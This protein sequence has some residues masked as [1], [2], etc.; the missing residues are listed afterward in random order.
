LR[1]GRGNAGESRRK[2]VRRDRKL[3]PI[4]AI[5]GGAIVLVVAIIVASQI[6]SSNKKTSSSTVQTDSIA[7]M[8]SGIPQKGIG[9]GNSNA[10]LTLVEFSDPQCPFCGEWARNTLPSLVQKYVRTGKLRIEYRGLAFLDDRNPLGAPRDSDRMLALAQA[11][12]LQDK[13]WNVVELEFENQGTENTGYAT[14]AYLRG[15]AQAVGNFNAGKAL[16]AASS[17]T[18]TGF[19]ASPDNVTAPRKALAANKNSITQA[20]YDAQVLAQTKVGKSISTPTF[21]IERTGSTKVGK[22]IVGALPLSTFTSAID[23]LL[24]K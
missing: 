13:L 11:A 2:T 19:F 5:V 14:D 4:L 21:L 10:K 24:K 9:L 1:N 20:V 22:T 18:V 7:E 12:G 6:G 23:A 16:S 17:S 15:I 8:L 3:A